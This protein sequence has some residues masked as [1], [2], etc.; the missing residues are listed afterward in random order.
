MKRRTILCAAFYKYATV[1][2]VLAGGSSTG[3]GSRGRISSCNTCT[4]R[5]GTTEF[6][7]LSTNGT[8]VLDIRRIA[9]GWCCGRCQP[10]VD[11]L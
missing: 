6:P 5:I 1:R 9:T 11:T 7:F 2:V 8:R 10:R 3:C 4:G